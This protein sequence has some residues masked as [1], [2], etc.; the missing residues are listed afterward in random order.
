LATDAA[1]IAGREGRSEGDRQDRWPLPPCLAA[2]AL[3][4]GLPSTRAPKLDPGWGLDR[5]SL[6]EVGAGTLRLEARSGSEPCDRRGLHLLSS[7]EPRNELRAGSTSVLHSPPPPRAE[8][9]RFD[10]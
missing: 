7:T 9:G 6:G 5:R 1:A 4:E 8:R 3:R 2:R 10:G